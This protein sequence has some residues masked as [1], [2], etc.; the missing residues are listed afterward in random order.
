VVD[1]WG[2]TTAG[3]SAQPQEAIF[4]PGAGLDPLSDELLAARGNL[5]AVAGGAAGRAAA[6]EFVAALVPA[7]YA[8]GGGADGLRRAVANAEATVPDPAALAFVAV[9]LAGDTLY[10]ARAGGGRAYRVRGETID[11]LA[12]ATA[13]AAV[14]GPAFSLGVPLR[15]GDRVVLCSP[16]AA[17]VVGDGQ[18][19]AFVAEQRAPR[20][21]A[22]RL[23]ALAR[24]RGATEDVSVVVAFVRAAPWFSHGQTAALLALG[25]AA[26]GAVGWLVWE[27]LRYWQAAG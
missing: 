10:L 7:Y 27:A 23:I 3:D 13:P 26:V 6:R 24:E 17:E 15:P 19:L 8:G 1:I 12:R 14:T 22:A 4:F 5:L 11:A 18:L 25:A 2:E 16:A 9:I 21:A 20:E